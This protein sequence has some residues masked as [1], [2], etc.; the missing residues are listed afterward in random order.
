M[1]SV[2]G[3]ARDGVAWAGSGEGIMTKLAA[4]RDYPIGSLL[5]WETQTMAH[6]C[7]ER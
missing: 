2:L 4:V 6:R 7:G 3:K 5:T 1:K